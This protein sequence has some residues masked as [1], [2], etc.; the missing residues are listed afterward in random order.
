M[1]KAYHVSHTCHFKFPVDA[2]K[3]VKKKKASDLILIIH[4]KPNPSKILSFQHVMNIK[5]LM[6]YVPFFSL[7]SFESW[8]ILY[9]QHVS[10]SD[11]ASFA[12]FSSHLWFSSV[13][14]G[15]TALD[16]GLTGTR[17]LGKWS[18]RPNGASD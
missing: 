5:Q 15:S 13:M 8:C 12:V 17:M 18:K 16:R 4:F 1:E 14:L 11:L 3:Q 6:G 9:L 10:E 2:Y 7:L